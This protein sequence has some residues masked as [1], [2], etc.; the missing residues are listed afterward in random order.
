M[1]EYKYADF[2]SWARLRVDCAVID[3]LARRPNDEQTHRCGY[4]KVSRM[5]F[6]CLWEQVS[7]R[8]AELEQVIRLSQCTKAIQPDVN[9]M[10]YCPS[11]FTCAEYVLCGL[12]YTL[13]L[14]MRSSEHRGMF[15]M[16]QLSAT[17]LY[18]SIVRACF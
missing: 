5:L 6:A 10:T 7:P 8:P 13:Q 17:A 18:Y 16:M 15:F 3:T 14:E 2:L 4:I 12:L 1:W 9:C 11:P